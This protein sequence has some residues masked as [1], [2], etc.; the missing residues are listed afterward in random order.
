MTKKG[1]WL[2]LNSSH[3]S[4]K[5]QAYSLWKF[6]PV[7]GGAFYSRKSPVWNFGNFHASNGK[8]HSRCTD[9]TQA[10][11]R[12][13]IVLESRIQKEQYWGQQFCQMERDIS[14]RPT[15]MSGPV[16][17]DHLQ[18]WSDQAEMVRS[19]WCTN[20]NYQNFGLNG[21]RPRSKSE[22]NSFNFESGGRWIM[23]PITVF[24]FV[25]LYF[26]F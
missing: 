14:V 6:F 20:R 5:I 15:E 24:S 2:D 4:L 26:L 21:K 1:G 9:P 17:V 16:T 11:A 10:T 8:V 22:R 7:L 19:I 13:V 23:P 18:S 12:L 3:P 25:L